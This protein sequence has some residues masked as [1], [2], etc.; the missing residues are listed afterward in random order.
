M[1]YSKWFRSLIPVCHFCGKDWNK[2]SNSYF[3]CDT[4]QLRIYL[5]TKKES[6]SNGQFDRI[7]YENKNK[8]IFY[9]DND[10]SVDNFV[11]N[12]INQGDDLNNIHNWKIEKHIISKEEFILLIKNINKYL[13]LL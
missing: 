8:I 1:L 13:V 3:I 5:T 9:I 6:N 7:I 12:L 11:L 10:E 4:C 2:T